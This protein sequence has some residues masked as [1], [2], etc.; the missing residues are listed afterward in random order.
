MNMKGLLYR[1]L[2]TNQYIDVLQMTSQA[3]AAT[4]VV[5]LKLL[6]N[7]ISGS[8]TLLFAR[9]D[10]HAPYYVFCLSSMLKVVIGDGHDNVNGQSNR[11]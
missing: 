1:H 3:L 8:T 7:V 11:R 4:M 6:Q 10:P 2:P 9:R 5:K